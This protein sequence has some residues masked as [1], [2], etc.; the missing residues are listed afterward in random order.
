MRL[1]VLLVTLLIVSYAIY[2]QVGPARPPQ[3]PTADT[4]TAVQP[5]RVPQRVE[6]LHDFE[7]QMQQFMN[8]S[9]TE[10]QRRMEEMDP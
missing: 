2:Q 1:I 10:R 8:A 4:E 5:P 3:A 9:G 6:E 7:S